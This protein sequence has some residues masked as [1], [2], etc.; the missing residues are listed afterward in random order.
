VPDVSPA[1]PVT[2][3][4]GVGP[5]RAERL[6]RLGI[7]TV[8]DL[9]R[10][11][12]RDYEPRG[13]VVSV[14][15]AKSRPRGDF[16]VVRGR[17]TSVTM[18]RIARGR[19]VLRARLEDASGSIHALWFNAP[20]LADEL[21]A[22]AE[23]ALSGRL[24]DA[25]ALVQAEIARVG[26]DGV[27]P[28]RLT[29][30]RPVYSL[31]DGVPAR[32]YRDCV[33]AALDAAA[34]VDDPLPEAAR[35][36]AGVLPLAPALRCAH[37]PGTAE[38]ARRGCERLLL[39]EILPLELAVRRRA[40]DRFRRTSPRPSLEGGGAGAFVDALSFELSPSQRTA[41]EEI[42]AD[43]ARPHPMSRLLVGEVGSGKTVVALAA[44]EEARSRGWQCALLAPTDMLARQ[45]WRTARGLLGGR[46]ELL[47]GT[48]DAGEAAAA[49]RRIAAGESELVVGTHALL[50]EST[51]FP[52]LGLVVIDEQHR[53]GVEQRAALLRRARTPH[54]LVLT[55]TPIPRTLA[56]LAFADCDLST[57]DPLAVSRGPV[58][59][60]L[61]A[62]RER[63]GA[64]A[65]VRTLLDGGQ[66][67][68]FVRPR[69]GGDE[70]G[71]EALH[72]EL[73]GGALRGL[74]VAL[75][76]GRLPPALR[77][78]R[79]EA[80]RRG[81]VRALVATTV[82]EVGLDVPG[83]T[84]L[85]V[86]G[87]ER[88]GLA[89]LHQLRG[90]IARRGQRGYCWLVEGADSPEGARQ[91]LE[92]VVEVDDGLRLAEIDLLARGPGELVGLKQSGRSA[93]LAN[94]GA[95]GSVRL[96]EIAE[97]ARL[98]AEAVLAA[99]EESPCA[100]RAEEASPSPWPSPR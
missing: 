21:P 68:F 13:D 65:R 94:L 70:G 88:F 44:A 55:A 80:F 37:R 35:A 79:L 29:G 67:A 95:D 14:A 34:D 82:V 73:A 7:A 60:R 91:R 66:Q 5:K 42:A 58:E 47:T 85:W 12:P 9:L 39:D 71:A 10:R 25:G 87:A 1:S 41:V 77:D 69:I 90:R 89:T 6:A 81:E 8:D 76:H 50:S 30:L 93:W 84:V 52:R 74:D 64:L 92:T 96:A 78:E 59:T 11:P 61:L 22:G 45:H 51:R 53:F 98:A 49:R 57:L 2:R 20:F 17:I 15:E 36:A 24:S 54:C 19:S 72:E 62:P 56:L 33:A 99:E 40:R 63:Q 16:A 75:V 31:T 32:L 86:E 43:L 48:L 46:V 97:R 18:R 3:L 100:Q 23:V 38:E 27:V 26:E 4:P 83:A 28:D